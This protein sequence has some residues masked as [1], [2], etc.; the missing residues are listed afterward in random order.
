MEFIAC[1]VW[2]WGHVFVGM[3]GFTGYLLMLPGRLIVWIA[4]RLLDVLGDD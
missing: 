3:L 1:F 4:D 2:I